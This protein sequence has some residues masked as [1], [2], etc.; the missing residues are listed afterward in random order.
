MKNAISLG[1]TLLCGS[2]FIAA[3]TAETTA[4]SAFCVVT[5]CAA[6]ALVLLINRK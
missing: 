2:A 4:Q 6:A 5:M 1:L 3:L